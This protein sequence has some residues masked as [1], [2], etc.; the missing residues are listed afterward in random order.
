RGGR[1]AP[2]PCQPHARST[3]SVVGPSEAP[4]EPLVELSAGTISLFHG[5]MPQAYEAIHGSCVRSCAKVSLGEGLTRSVGTLMSCTTLTLLSD[6]MSCID[7]G[8]K[9]CT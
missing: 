2:R 1:S 4:P 5:P 8:S 9:L 3:R 7:V 6:R